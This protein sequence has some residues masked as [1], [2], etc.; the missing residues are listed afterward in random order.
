MKLSRTLML[1]SLTAAI[2][3]GCKKDNDDE[4]P[5]ITVNEPSNNFT[6]NTGAD[7]HFEAEFTDNEELS[8]YKIEIHDN[9]DGHTHEKTETTPWTVNQIVDITGKSKT[10]HE[11]IEV[12][13]DA[14]AGPY[15]FIVTCLD[16]AGN[17]ADFVELEFEVVNTS[18]VVAPTIDITSPTD[19]QQF[20]VG[21]NIDIIGTVSDDQEVEEVEV[22]IEREA[23]ETEVHDEDIHVHAQSG[24][25]NVSVSTNGWSAG[26]YHI[27]ISATDHVNNKTETEIEIE[28]N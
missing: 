15:H 7:I 2:I 4:K 25:I 24:N 5:V 3:T 6:A 27:H 26:G 28:V 23:D 14:P 11:H 8:Q 10:V 12:P 1:L 21:D 18:D 16:A 20:T 19:G 13:S 17:E 22:V 9:F